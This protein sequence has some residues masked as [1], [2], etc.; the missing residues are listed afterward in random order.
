M[1]DRAPGRRGSGRAE[2]R[3][4]ANR[5][6]SSIPLPTRACRA[7]QTRATVSRIAVANACGASSGEKCPLPGIGVT[8]TRE[9]YASSR[10]P[11]RAREER[12]VFGPEDMGRLRYALR[13]RRRALGEARGDRAGSGAIPADRRDE[14]SGRRVALDELVEVR[15]GELEGRVR[16]S[17]SRSGV[18]TRGPHPGCRPAAGRRARAGGTPGIRTRAGHRRSARDRRRRGQR[19]G[20]HERSARGSPRVSQ[21]SRGATGPATRGPSDR[22]PARSRRSA[23]NAARPE[24]SGIV[25]GRRVR[26]PASARRCPA[27][28]GPR[29]RQAIAPQGSRRSAT[30]G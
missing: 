18:G 15:V 21:A 19:R 27:R 28:S 24:P 25:S 14:R 1:E 4:L 12:V 3:I 23:P 30:A 2:R 10:S 26:G 11:P 13:G 9:K 17:G 6:A 8:V 20:E 7:A 5:R 22:R 29:C 16:T